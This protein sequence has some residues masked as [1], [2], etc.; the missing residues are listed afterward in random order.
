MSTRCNA[1]CPDCPRNL[2]GVDLVDDYPVHDMTLDEAKTIFTPEFIRQLQVI[3][4]N[5]N[6]E[7]GRAHV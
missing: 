1:A 3:Q 2:R 5:G 7:I 6:L 4:I